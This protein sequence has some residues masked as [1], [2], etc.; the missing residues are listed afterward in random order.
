M[1]QQA[2]AP[3]TSELEGLLVKIVT[4]LMRMLTRLGYLV[5]EE[6]MSYLADTDANKP[7]RSLRAAA[8]TYRIAYGP[9]TGQKVLCLQT[10]SCRGEYAG[11]A[12]CADAH[13]F[14]LHAVARCGA[15]QR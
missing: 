8:C 2:R 9:C 4:R 6:D 10:I 14:S 12:L 11:P 3:N 1:F 5:E 7:L 13:G 15:H